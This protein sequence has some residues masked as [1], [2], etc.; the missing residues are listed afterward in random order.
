MS[1]PETREPNVARE[2]Q[3][4][5]IP[6]WT[7]S[8]VIVVALVFVVI[9]WPMNAYAARFP[10]LAGGMCLVLGVLELTAQY[11]RHR[12]GL[13]DT[14]SAEPADRQ[15]RVES[16]IIISWVFLSVL[17]IYLLGMLGTAFASTLVY[18][19]VIDKRSW[20]VSVVMGFVV[21]VFLWISFDVLAGF[22]IY[23]GFLLRRLT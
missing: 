17:S 13:A 15:A 16:A 1:A 5:W 3:G 10:L 21:A 20:K 6:D 19:R 14:A 18:Y 22:Y 4:I 8:L 9:A 2:R 11:L 12:S 23:E 7:V